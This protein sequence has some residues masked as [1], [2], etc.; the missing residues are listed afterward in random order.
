M[1]LPRFVR[2]AQLPLFSWARCLC[3]LALLGGQPSLALDP[4]RK[5][6]QYGHVAWQQKQ[7]LPQNTIWSIAQTPDGYLWL[8]TEE[9]LVRFD[10][11]AF[12]VFDKGNT[13]EIRNN[14][15]RTLLVDR[16]GTLWFGTN[17]ANGGGLCR[18]VQGRFESYASKIGLPGAS[19]L[20]LLEDRNG[21]LWIGTNSGLAHLSNDVIR[22]YSMSDGLSSEMII[23][24]RQD[25]SG[26]L[27]V[28][29]NKGLNRFSN[30]RFERIAMGELTNDRVEV[31]CEDKE[32]GLFIGTG[33]GRLWRMREGRIRHVG[34]VPGISQGSIQALAIDGKGSLWIGSQ[35]NGLARYRSGHFETFGRGDGLTDQNVLSL[36]EDR[37][38]SLWVGTRT[39]GLN[40]LRDTSFITY[41]TR[42]GLP[43]EPVRAILQGRDGAM[44]LGTD[45]P[46]GLVRLKD[47]K[48]T[49]LGKREGLTSDGVRSL[50][51]GWDGAIWIGTYAGLNR[52]QEGKIKRFTSKQGL[53]S[54][55]IYSLL[56]GADGSVWIGTNAGGLNQLKGDRISSYPKTDGLPHVTVTWLLEGRGG[57]LWIGTRRGLAV[58]K[59]GGI[60]SPLVGGDSPDFAVRCFFEDADGSIWIGTAG[61]GL[62]RLKDGK[63]ASITTKKGL[64]H[65]TVYRILDD[66]LGHF[67]MSCNKGVFRADKRELAGV[68][69]GTRRAIHCVAYGIPDGMLSDECNGGSQPAGWKTRDGKLWFPTIQ[70]VAVVDPAHLV[71]NNLP[72]PVHIESVEINQQPVDPSSLVHVPA[73]AKSLEIHCTALSFLVPERVRFK[74]LMEGFDSDWIEAGTRRTAY[75]TSLPPGTFRFHVRACNNDGVWNMDG[76]SILFKVA[77]HYYQTLWF[78]G[79]C[80]LLAISL[81]AII[82]RHFHQV[83]IHELEMQNRVLD[84]RHRLARDVHDQL[85]QTMTG[86]LLQLEAAGHALLLGPE[87]CRPY[88]DRAGELAREGIAETRRTIQGLRATA[89]DDGELVSALEAI[90]LRL[91]EGTEVQVI[92]GQMG[93]PFPLP[94]TVEDDLFRV[95]QEGITNALRHGHARR[96]EVFLTW[97]EDGLRLAINDD[98]L[99]LDAPQDPSVPSAG[100]GLSGMWERISTDKGTLKVGNRSEG[101]TVVEVFI[102]RREVSG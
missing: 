28:G 58:L 90:A 81:G 85:S 88:L 61:S 27:F 20:R 96:I 33:D 6:T 17:G 73:G 13:P 65:D 41:S 1:S 18:M 83:R 97:E 40:R 26:Q 46:G 7:G 94:R 38:G 99:G 77:P 44:W 39:G 69:D 24:L 54:E 87:R 100:L 101:G 86:L 62:K 82:Q 52:F 64:F 29:T 74:Y 9:G 68:A 3:L 16:Q 60:T 95:G 55:D 53:T 78:Y 19:V 30:G 12:K 25:R 43:T 32:G 56:Q 79:L 102:P 22:T 36:L 84:E 63:L 92:V 14:Y 48:A 47:G 57:N 42:E 70:G 37:E 71:M 31:I 50:A 45:A 10:G 76:A 49:R 75:Y 2:F 59:D 51:E 67:W 11:V 93:V 98:G 21:G 66:G 4:E 5:I 91:I 8:A 89:L 23:A 35:G 34:Q 15:I 72:P 80:G